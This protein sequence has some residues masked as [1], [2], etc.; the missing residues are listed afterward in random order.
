MIWKN[1]KL[2]GCD[3]Q[4]AK[5]PFASM[6]VMLDP[7]Y[8]SIGLYSEKYQSCTPDALGDL[9]AT[10]LDGED[11]VQFLQRV[12]KEWDFQASYLDFN[13]N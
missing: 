6:M 1:V 3:V 7:E 10:S 13:A 4:I 9:L 12:F 8:K 5:V 11:V 2:L